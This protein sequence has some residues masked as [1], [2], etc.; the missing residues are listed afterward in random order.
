MKIEKVIHE[1]IR[2]KEKSPIEEFHEIAATQA[3]IK[4]INRETE[5]IRKH[6]KL[7]EKPSTLSYQEG[8]GYTLK[9]LR[10]I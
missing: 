9:K 7:P 4:S 3:R 1:Y 10:I 8:K 2:P 6:G 5:Y